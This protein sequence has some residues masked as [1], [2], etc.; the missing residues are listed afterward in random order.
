MKSALRRV[1]GRA[2]P[3]PLRPDYL[4]AL[5]QRPLPVYI[6]EDPFRAIPTE[7]VERPE[8][9]IACVADELSF[10]SWQY[11]ADFVPLHRKD[12]RQ[13]LD[14]GSFDL[15]LIESAWEGPGGKWGKALAD[16]PRKGRRSDEFLDQVVSGFQARGIPTVF[17]AKEDP[18]DRE[19][20]LGAAERFDFVFTT[21][22]DSI[23]FYEEELGHTRVACLPFAAQP[24]LHHP[25]ADSQPRPGSVF[26]A[27]TWYAKR[28][29]QRRQ[30]AENLLGPAL[31]HGPG[32]LRP[33]G[34]AGPHRL[35]VAS[36]VRGGT[37][38][39]GSVCADGGSG[40]ALPGRTQPQFHH[41]LA[42]HAL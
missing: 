8:L 13:T 37:R 2:R 35:S 4:E 18:V 15:L 17:Y 39:D 7:F 9:R 12:W 25:P 16:L 30:Q 1:A 10:R 42:H 20:F 21:D 26:F 27:G 19:L 34:S 22:E 6:P 11:E 33:C 32:H 38:W 3:A 28:H 40:G 5:L 24:R 23:S 36:R 14:A 29:P 31:E 41:H